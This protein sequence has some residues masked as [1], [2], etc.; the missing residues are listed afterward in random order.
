MLAQQ[1]VNG[2]MLGSIYAFV[3]V[4]YTLVFGVLKMLNLAQSYFFMIAPFVAFWLVARLGV[5][6]PIAMVLSLGVTS[7]LGILLYYV[8]FRPVPQSEPLG[9]FVS[10]LSFGV[11]LQVAVINY[12]GTLP[13]SF[14]VTV[15]LPD[16]RVAGVLISVLQLISLALSLVL[17]S[18]LFWLVN[19]TPFGRNAR[20]I[21]ENDTAAALLGANTHKTIVYI[22]VLSSVLAGLAGLFVAVRFGTISP[23]FSDRLAL[24]AL[25]VIV[26]GGL[27]DLRGALIGGI[28]LGMIE[29]LFQAYLP[30]GWSEAFIWLALIVI[31][32]FRPTGLFGAGARRREV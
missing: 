5:P 15:N 17:M 13:I 10:S 11:L 25:A 9:G 3:G 23:F 14:P 1:V 21:A 22:F 2:L 12:F 27:G 20:A 29:V 24:K 30:P 26:I 19:Y 6:S 16:V 7:A 18:G 28:V 31:L 8:S 32:I 4:G